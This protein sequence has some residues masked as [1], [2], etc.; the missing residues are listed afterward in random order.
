VA[1]SSDTSNQRLFF[2]SDG[3]TYYQGFNSNGTYNHEWRHCGGTTTMGLNGTRSLYLAHQLTCK[4]Y[5]IPSS[6][7][8][9]I[10]VNAN[11]GS[12]S[13]G[14]LPRRR[15]PFFITLTSWKAD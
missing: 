15:W 1:R 14:F 11:T 6:N 12:G 7:T 3:T 8:D 2:A 10:G 9:Y 5:T 13:N 4:F